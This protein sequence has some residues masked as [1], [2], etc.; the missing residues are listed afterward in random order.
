MQKDATNPLYQQLLSA[1][2]YKFIP[3]FPVRLLSLEQDSVVTRVNSDVAYAYFTQQNSKGSYQETLVPNSD[4]MI[5]DGEYL[6]NGEV[7]HVTEVPFMSIL[8]L[9]QINSLQ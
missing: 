9:N 3:Q 7:D 4:F 8:I 6:S 1:D 5:S 2:T